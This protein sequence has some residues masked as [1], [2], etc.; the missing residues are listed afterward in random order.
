MTKSKNVPV[1]FIGRRPWTDH[2]YGSKLPFEPG[3][4]RHVP[5]ELARRFLRHQDVFQP[6]AAEVA[7]PI[8]PAAEQDTKQADDTAEILADAQ[9]QAQQEQRTNVELQDL[10]DRVALMDKDALIEFATNNYRMPLDKRRSEQNLREQVIG[11]INQYG[12]V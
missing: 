2:L 8:E 9:L 12:V 3:Q 10:F 7:E 11:F 4:V 5:T 1:K 6:H